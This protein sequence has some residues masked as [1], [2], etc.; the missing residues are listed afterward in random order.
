MKELMRKQLNFFCSLIII[1]SC[2]IIQAAT[3]VEEC[4]RLFDENLYQEAIA[5]CTAAV[6]TGDSAV[7][8]MLGEIYDQKGNSEKTAFWWNKASDAGYQPARN[9]LALKYF[10]GG[11]VFGPEKGWIQDYSKA[12]IIWKEDADRGIATSQFM[13]GVMHQKGLGVIKDLSKAWFW[14][15]VSLGNG[16]KLSTDVLIEISREITPVQRRLGEEKLAKYQKQKAGK[17]IDKTVTN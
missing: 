8:T 11:T 6:K 12:Y 17:I 7:Q 9:L 16:Y 3:P 4:K 10:Y 5:S 15:K 14:H 13:L 2:S 1:T